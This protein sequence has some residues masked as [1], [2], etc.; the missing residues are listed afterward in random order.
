MIHGKKNYIKYA[1]LIILIC[2]S[3]FALY[4][5]YKKPSMP[6]QVQVKTLD[7]RKILLTSGGFNSDTIIS[8]KTW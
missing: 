5:L 1:L 7:K 8:S 2:M 6:N 3:A 4:K